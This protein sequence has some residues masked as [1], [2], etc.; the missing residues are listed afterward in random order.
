MHDESLQAVVIQSCFE[1]R[2]WKEL[3][4]HFGVFSW[5]ALILNSICYRGSFGSSTS[6][7]RNQRILVGKD[8][9]YGTT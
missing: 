3:M 8:T 7:A 4:S 2:L 1:R 5:N 9:T 6:D